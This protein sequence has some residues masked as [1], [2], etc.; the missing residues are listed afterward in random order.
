M[1]TADNVSHPPCCSPSIHPTNRS[2]HFATVLVHSP[3]RYPSLPFAQPHA[4]H[5]HPAQ[6]H[7]SSR[8]FQVI[9]SPMVQLQSLCSAPVT[10]YQ[11]MPCSALWMG[12]NRPLRQTRYSPG[13]FASAAPRPPH[14][15]RRPTT[16]FGV[17]Y[18]PRS[19]SPNHR[20]HPLP[21][22]RYATPSATIAT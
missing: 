2:T 9:A 6:C 8:P 11:C 22:I 12:I 4:H 5:A 18:H 17:F 21:T 7:R 15:N 1:L 10:W 16:V 14:L 3:T 13:Y 19:V 20:P